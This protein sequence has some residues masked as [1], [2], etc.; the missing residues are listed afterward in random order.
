M[1]SDEMLRKTAATAIMNMH[2]G[3]SPKDAIGK[4]ALKFSPAGAVELAD[5]VRSMITI[6]GIE[7]T[8]AMYEAGL[9]EIL[10]KFENDEFSS[11]SD[12]NG[13]SPSGDTGHLLSRPGET[14]DTFTANHRPLESE[15]GNW[16]IF[17]IFLL[18]M[19][20]YGYY[21]YF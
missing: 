21:K 8:P 19:A 16:K 10:A 6:E 13:S 18:L 2:A 20:I 7:M 3:M 12:N 5:S 17:S 1:I 9:Q 14:H 11:P 15:T 4:A